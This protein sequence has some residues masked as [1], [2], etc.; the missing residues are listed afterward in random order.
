MAMKIA[1][2]AIWLACSNPALIKRSQV[3]QSLERIVAGF[4][5]VPT[6]KVLLPPIRLTF[7][8]FRREK[9]VK[10]HSKNVEFGKVE[11]A[12]FSGLVR[13]RADTVSVL[14]ARGP[15]VLRVAW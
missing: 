14:H 6:E 1:N 5:E 3:H 2:Q 11:H 9:L 15:E 12:A 10:H 7:K 4:F 13:Y 8:F